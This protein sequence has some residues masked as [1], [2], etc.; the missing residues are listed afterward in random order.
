MWIG[1]LFWATTAFAQSSHDDLSFELTVILTDPVYPT[2]EAVQ[3]RLLKAATIFQEQCGIE[4]KTTIRHE[5]GPTR[6]NFQESA[7]FI[8]RLGLGG[9]PVLV[10]GDHYQTYSGAS[11]VSFAYPDFY[12]KSEQYSKDYSTLQK[13]VGS[14]WANYGAMI[15]ED[16]PSDYIV[17]AHEI[18]HL[19]GL[20][21]RMWVNEDSVNLMAENADQL[22]AKLEV[23]QCYEMQQT[24]RKLAQ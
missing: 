16:Y 21:H 11:S 4:M 14:A 22:G 12:V 8:E 10:Y 3:A 19:L 24:V 1:I 7:Q 18:V 2:L 6:A 9:K 23:D 15:N 17:E 20:D 13:L 5:N